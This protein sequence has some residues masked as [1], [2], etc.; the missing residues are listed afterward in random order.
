MLLAASKHAYVG[1][2][3]TKAWH[4][5]DGDLRMRIIPNPGRTFPGFA[6][7]PLVRLQ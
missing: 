5:A 2:A 7:Q 4:T 6:P 1:E 3:P